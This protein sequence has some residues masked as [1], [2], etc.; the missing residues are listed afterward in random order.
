MHRLRVVP[1]ALPGRLHRSGRTAAGLR[2]AQARA[3]SHP[4]PRRVSQASAD[5]RLHDF[6]GGLALDGHKAVSLEV[7]LAS[8]GLPER[9]YV[10][11]G[12]HQGEAGDL[13]L[14]PGDQVLAGQALTSSADDFEVPAHAPCSG[15]VV[16]LCERPASHPPGSRRR[17][18]EILNDGRDEWVAPTPLKHWAEC[19]SG[20]I[21]DHLH[22]MGLVG[23]GGAMFPTAAKLRGPWGAIH[24][25]IL[26]GAECEP[27][28]SCDEMLMRTRPEAVIRGGQVLAAAVAAERVIIAVEDDMDGI[29]DALKK[30]LAQQHGSL[31]MVIVEVPSVYPQGGE[32]QLIETLTGLQVP[33]DGLPQD[34]GLLCHNVATAAAAS[35]AVVHGRPLTERIVTVTGPGIQRPC[36]LRAAVGTPVAHLV[37]AAGGYRDGVQRLV[38]GGPMSGTA[39]SSDEV[40]LTKGSHCVL[41]LTDQELA[42]RPE[43]MPC[44]NCGDCVAVCPASLMPQLLFRA[45]AAD[46]HEQ[47]R[48]LSLL[49][50]IECGCC[51]QVCPS[52]IPLVDYY[53]HGKARLGLK[54]LDQRR[55]ALAKRRY[56][57]R[58]QRLAQQQADREARRR[59]RAERLQKAGGARDEIQAAIERAKAKKRSGD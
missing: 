33:G 42:P 37:A 13:L 50:C 58:E 20:K 18:I 16:G 8:A 3:H 46:R 10:P 24:T 56:E 55:A 31:E 28:I 49:E 9:V 19:P 29:A 27:W 30:A 39:L 36:N 52:Q 6:H 1:A 34:I 17:C 41:A 7:P 40:V 26:N 44:I 45:L 54:D 11:I 15:T 25:L 32:R 53:R 47:A 35:D 23:L 5:F 43:P 51:A 4:G 21:V 2:A 14:G 12:Q 22:A 59:A 57:A 48:D 38:L